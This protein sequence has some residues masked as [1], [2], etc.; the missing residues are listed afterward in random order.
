MI[1]LQEKRMEMVALATKVF[2]EIVGLANYIRNDEK[3]R[4]GIKV[5]VWEANTR[6]LLLF[7]VGKPSEAA[8]VFVV[9]KA[10]RAAVDHDFSSGNGANPNKM[11]FAGCVGFE[12]NGQFLQVSVSGLQEK[13]DVA[14][15]TIL[16]AHLI[17]KSPWQLYKTIKAIAIMPNFLEAEN[18]YL[19][20]IIKIN[21]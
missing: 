12:F 7:S 20:Q 16:L 8:E 6:N 10:V 4:T 14:V 11:K 18:D 3:E 21:S 19:G 1:D 9:E 5:L 13:E 15:A 2:K 17:G